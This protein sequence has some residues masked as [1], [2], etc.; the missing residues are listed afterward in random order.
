[1][2]L[3]ASIITTVNVKSTSIIRLIVN[4]LIIAW[5]FELWLIIARRISSVV[6]IIDDVIVD[7][8]II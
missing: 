2:A 8:R 3:V 7:A 4:L 5:V 1:M 6:I